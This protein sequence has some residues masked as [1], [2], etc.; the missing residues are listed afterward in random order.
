MAFVGVSR[1]TP[2]TQRF[3]R[4]DPT[5]ET[6]GTNFQVIISLWKTDSEQLPVTLQYTYPLQKPN[7]KLSSQ[8]SK[9]SQSLWSSPFTI[10]YIPLI[11]TQRC[12]LLF[13]TPCYTTWDV[14]GGIAENESNFKGPQ[15]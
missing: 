7:K 5:T 14:L 1:K 13:P 10:R 2:N 9:T 3:Q 6:F 12:R 11:P 8:N 4:W 15:T